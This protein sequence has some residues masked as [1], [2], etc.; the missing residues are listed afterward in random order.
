MD[1]KWQALE[2]ETGLSIAR[3]V[4]LKRF[5]SLGIGGY[6]AGAVT[7]E[8]EKS[9][10]KLIPAA[11]KLGI[12]L[13]CLGGGT[14][15]VFTDA[16]FG[17]LIVRLG[18]GFKKIEIPAADPMADSGV[19]VRAGAAV[20]LTALI[21]RTMEAGLS[22]VEKLAGIP[23]TLGGSIYQNSGARDYDVSQAVDRVTFWD[24]S[25]R[26]I[27]T[28]PKDQLDFR[29]RHSLFHSLPAVILSVDLRLRT[30]AR[31]TILAEVNARM[32]HRNATQ[33]AGRSVGC[34]FKNPPDRSAGQLIDKAGLKGR[35][36]GGL[37]VSEVHGNFFLNDGRATF[38]DFEALVAMVREAVRNQ[39][40]LKLEMEVEIVHESRSAAPTKT[41]DR[42]VPQDQERPQSHAENR[43]LRRWKISGEGH[44]I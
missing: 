21:T 43:P 38:R 23:G 31:E 42:S 16:G 33:P 36:V 19:V 24:Q 13:K 17:G 5:S 18:E 7:V 28:L 25:Q 26:R 9:L 32:K 44:F 22:G 3:D 2:S 35:R 40:G 29:Y 34:I 11:S 8:Q 37:T 39:F 12:S 4:S 10:E 15:V 6:A 30:A 14:N 27:R 41:G 1:N 20:H